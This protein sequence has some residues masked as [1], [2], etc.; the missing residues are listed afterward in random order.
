MATWT[1]MPSLMQTGDEIEIV[2]SPHLDTSPWLE[3]IWLLGKLSSLIQN[4]YGDIYDCVDFYKQPAFDHPLLANHSFHPEVQMK[5]STLPFE[6]ESK[7]SQAREVLT[8]MKSRG[9][10]CPTGTIPIKRV[11]KDDFIKIKRFTEDYNSRIKSNSL[12]NHFAVVQT[13]NPNPKY[14]YGA[15]VILSVHNFNVS[16]SQYSSAG[17][18]LTNGD[19]TIKFGWTDPK[20]GNWWLTLGEENTLQRF[21]PG[22]IFNGLSM[23]A[24]TVAFGGEAYGPVDQPLPP[25]GNG[26]FGVA[27]PKYAAYCRAIAVLDENLKEDNDPHEIETYRDDSHYV[28]TDYG[29]TNRF[30]RIMFYGG[31][32]PQI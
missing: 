15:K 10:G 2:E 26:Y 6:E 31:T 8:N 7:I 14:Y 22:T 3:E 25:M 16:A 21:W 20:D 5:P 30:G 4:E 19:D 29:W 27:D 32:T 12:E 1:S 18:T 9:E 24:T 17:M 23:L 13:P 28:V 11:S